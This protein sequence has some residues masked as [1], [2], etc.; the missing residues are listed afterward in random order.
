MR[1]GRR[2]DGENIEKL[3]MNMWRKEK[4]EIIVKK[5]NGNDMS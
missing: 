1:E 3:W 2:E 5:D 4:R